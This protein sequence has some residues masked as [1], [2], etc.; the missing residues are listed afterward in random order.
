MRGVAIACEGGF[1]LLYRG[2]ADEDRFREQLLPGGKNFAFQSPDA[3]PQI[4]E[5]NGH[6]KDLS[7][8]SYLAAT[9]SVTRRFKSS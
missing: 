6:R 8:H 3:A 5:R 4:N 7:T 2:A 9:Q 1:E